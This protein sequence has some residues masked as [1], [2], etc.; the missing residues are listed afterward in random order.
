MRVEDTIRLEK[1]QERGVA[2]QVRP[3]RWFDDIS[4]GLRNGIKHF[5]N[6]GFFLSH[7]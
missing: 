4:K 3:E 1:S 2:V 7:S 5:K 6:T